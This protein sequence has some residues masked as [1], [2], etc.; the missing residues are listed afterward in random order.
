MFEILT[1]TRP[2][3]SE[4]Y[5]NGIKSMA[6]ISRCAFSESCILRSCGEK[7]SIRAFAFYTYFEF[8]TCGWM[9]HTRAPP[10]VSSSPRDSEF[11]TMTI[12]FSVLKR[13]DIL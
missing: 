13:D 11:Y 3:M 10:A 2:R 8:N 1:K 4:R 9:P 5:R 6:F 12:C 7:L